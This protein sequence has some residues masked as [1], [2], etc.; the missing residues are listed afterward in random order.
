MTQRERI[1]AVFKGETP[2][3]VPYMLDL[4]HY[5]YQS[6]KLPWD[7]SVAFEL[8]E[9]ELI[10]Y[11]RKVGAGFYMPNLASVYITEY[12]RDVLAKTE[13]KIV[14]GAPEITWR[15]ETPIGAIERVRRWEE[16]TYSW[17]IRRWGVGS[18]QDL[19]VLAYA[20]GDRTYRAAWEKYVQWVGYIGEIG[21]CYLSV[22]YSAMGCLLHQWMGVERTIYAVSDWPDTMRE[23]VT[24]I[25]ENSLRLIDLAAMSPAE[26]IIMGDNFSSDVQPPRFFETWSQPFYQEAIL[27]LHEAGKRVAVHIDGKLRGAIRMIRRTGADCGDAITP[28]PMGDMTPVECREEAGPDFILSG[29]VSPNLW[30][31]NTPLEDFKHAV[32]AWLD[33][34]RVSKRLI[35][36]AGDQVP[37]GAVEDRIEAMRDLVEKHG[38]Y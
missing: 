7:L 1:M 32:V 38:K 37:P 33:L 19:K 35:A 11:H 28:R 8:P 18:E 31:P 16:T 22:G 30:L 12:P 25:N 26:I 27:R 29:G 36:N 6:R 34:K 3:V 9:Y 24:R 10:D 13:K 17:G 4:S 21:V 5:Y 23:V 20:L 2:D 15:F 14:D